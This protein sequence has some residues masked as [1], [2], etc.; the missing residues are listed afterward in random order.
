MPRLSRILA[1]TG[2]LVL[3]GVFAGAMAAAFGLALSLILVG[4]WRSALNPQ[5]LRFSALVGAVIGAVAAPITSW[6]FLR[7][8]PFGKM[9]LQTTLATALAGGI[10]FALN[11]SPFL[12]AGLGFLGA[13]VRLA[14]V[15]PRRPAIDQLPGDTPP[16][17]LGA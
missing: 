8:V 15:S 11:F 9:I 5:L 10:G 14:V 3:A 16:G 7:H 6:L 12:F 2:G 17:K 13:A 4:E 1:V